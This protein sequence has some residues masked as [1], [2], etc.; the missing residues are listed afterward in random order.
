MKFTRHLLMVFVVLAVICGFALLIGH[1]GGGTSRG[2]PGLRQQ[3]PGFVGKGP[4]N[5]GPGS[6]F[7][8]RRF[9]PGQQGLNWSSVIQTIILGTG[10][11]GL[12]LAVDLSA[13]K[14]RRASG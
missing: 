6:G 4:G 5:R 13:R 12:V 3:V 7:V 9:G 10:I 11:A 14:R 2:L 1:S 8:F